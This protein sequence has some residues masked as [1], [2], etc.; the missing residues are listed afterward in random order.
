VTHYWTTHIHCQHWTHKTQDEDV[1]GWLITGQHIDTVSIGHTKLRTKTLEGDSLL[2]NT[3]TLPALRPEFCVSNAGSVYVLSSNESPS[4]VFVLSCVCPIL[5]VSMCCPVM[6]HPLT[7]TTWVL[8]VQCWQCL[9]VVIIQQSKKKKKKKKKK[10]R[11]KIFL[12]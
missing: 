3:Y 9:W 2:D 8:C 6:S 7:S 4:S 1:R 11:K 10:K 12:G 5:A